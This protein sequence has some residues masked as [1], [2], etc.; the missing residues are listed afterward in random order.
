MGS[1]VLRPGEWGVKA[2]MVRVSWHIKLYEPLQNV[3]HMS[4]FGGV[5]V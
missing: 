2:G 4:H 1:D 5:S 3:R